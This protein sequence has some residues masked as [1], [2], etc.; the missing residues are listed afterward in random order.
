MAL[1]KVEKRRKNIPW[2]CFTEIRSP[3][4]SLSEA[5]EQCN[6]SPSYFAALFRKQFGLSF[7]RY[8]RN[9]RLNGAISAINHGTTFKEAAEE[10]GFFDKSHLARLIKQH[11]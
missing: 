3:A 10:W 7:A 11:K 1:K 5:A 6:L 4:L 8:E 9:F 2:L